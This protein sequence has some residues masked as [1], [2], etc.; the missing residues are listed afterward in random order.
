VAACLG[1]PDNCTT[2]HFYCFDHNTASA[3][4]LTHPLVTIGNEF[5]KLFD[6]NC[7]QDERRYVWNAHG[8]CLPDQHTTTTTKPTPPTYP[9]TEAPT[10]PINQ[11]TE[12]STEHTESTTEAPTTYPTRTSP[13]TTAPTTH[14]TTPTVTPTTID[15]DDNFV[16]PHGGNDL[17]P[18]PGHCN[19][20]YLCKDGYPAKMYIF[21]CPHGSEFDPSN[22]QCVEGGHFHC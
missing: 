18:R 6:T 12:E 2:L 22:K 11:T 4:V 14:P 15:P 3:Y 20:F 7:P 5:A 8:D 10:P 13:R 16:C 17:F 9:T 19:Q 21:N 1:E